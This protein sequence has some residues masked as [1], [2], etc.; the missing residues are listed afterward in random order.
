MV[1]DLE[2]RGLGLGTVLVLSLSM[3]LDKSFPSSGSQFV[4]LC[5]RK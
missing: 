2:S 5:E 3:D 4:H 1:M